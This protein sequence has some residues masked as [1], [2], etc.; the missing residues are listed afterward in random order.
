MTRKHLHFGAD[1][2]EIIIIIVIV[3]V[4]EIGGELGGPP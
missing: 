3:I 4:M 2:S 1:D